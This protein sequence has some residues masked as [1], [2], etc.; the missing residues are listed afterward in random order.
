MIEKIIS[1]R[2][3]VQPYM[4]L[5]REY[6]GAIKHSINYSDYHLSIH[7]RIEICYA[8]EER[9]EGQIHRFLMFQCG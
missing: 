2:F 6:F 9:L 5:G 3:T 7:M 4:K 8:Y 1:E